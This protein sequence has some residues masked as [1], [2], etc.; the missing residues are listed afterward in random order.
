MNVHLITQNMKVTGPNRRYYLNQFE[1]F[2]AKV[3]TKLFIEVQFGR[4]DQR[5]GFSIAL[6]DHNGVIAHQKH[7]DSK[8]MMFGYIVGCNT[9]ANKGC[10]IKRLD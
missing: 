7:F 8:D 6:V 2:A 9:Y 4:Q 10:V 3:S 5:G 1:V